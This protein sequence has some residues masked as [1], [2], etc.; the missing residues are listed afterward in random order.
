[1]GNLLNIVIKYALQFCHA[2]FQFHKAQ[3]HLAV[4]IKIY[5]LI[6]ATLL[7]KM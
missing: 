2:V 4:F 1:M 5:A 6:N 7:C 3:G